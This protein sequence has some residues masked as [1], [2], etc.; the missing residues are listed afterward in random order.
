MTVLYYLVS[1]KRYGIARTAMAFR[2]VVARNYSSYLTRTVSKSHH[3]SQA[4]AYPRFDFCSRSSLC[5][6]SHRENNASRNL[7]VRASRYQ[8]TPIPSF[9]PLL[10]SGPSASRASYSTK[11]GYSERVKVILKE[12]GR[13]GFVFYM[14]VSL[15]SLGTCYLLVNK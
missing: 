9:Y 1:G 7:C 12:Y 15:T 14:I 8:P 6:F 5:F 2:V 4:N 3:I 13:V 11:P 10:R